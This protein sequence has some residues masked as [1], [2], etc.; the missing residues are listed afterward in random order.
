[1][2]KRDIFIEITLSVLLKSS[3]VFLYFRKIIFRLARSRLVRLRIIILYLARLYV[4]IVRFE[5][6]YARLNRKKD[7][8]KIKSLLGTKNRRVYIFKL[9]LR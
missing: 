7:H 6:L 8:S 5:R 9:F 4:V 3:A 2:N 1:M